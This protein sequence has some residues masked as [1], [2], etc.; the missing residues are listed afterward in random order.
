MFQHFRN[1]FMTAAFVTS[2]AILSPGALTAQTT[3]QS[4]FQ[5][6]A[7]WVGKPKTC[8]GSGLYRVAVTGASVYGENVE[9]DANVNY[10]SGTFNAVNGNVLTGY[11]S[12]F[13]VKDNGNPP[14]LEVSPNYPMTLTLNDK[15][16]AT[17][18]ITD[19]FGYGA[20]DS[21]YLSINVG[22]GGGANS[23]SGISLTGTMSVAFS[24]VGPGPCLH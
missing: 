2:L 15:D 24:K 19:P 21:G 9:N 13:Q 10:I 3:V 17:L 1:T 6:L 5:D 20:A 18:Q 4:V 7:S 23:F 12:V 22:W 16:H 8:G 14:Q 11:A